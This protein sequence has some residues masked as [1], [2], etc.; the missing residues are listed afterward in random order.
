MRAAQDDAVRDLA[1]AAGVLVEWENY[2]GKR[3]EVAVDA[4][5]AVLTALGHPCGTDGDIAESR[6]RLAP[7]PGLD[8]LPPLITATEG[9][10][11]RLS[12]GAG[13]P[14][15]A[16]L[17]SETG[18]ERDLRLHP[19]RNGVEL[20]AISE[21]GYHRLLIG[22]RAL[23]L[24]VAPKHAPLPN[25][26]AAD[27]DDD[28]GVRPWGIA[29]QAYGLRRPG[30]GGIGDMECVALLAES[31]AR[32][33][34][35]MLA[36]SPLH[37]LFSAE[38]HRYGPYSPSSRL[39]LNPLYATPE[40]VLGQS[41]VARAAR[42][43]GVSAALARLEGLK[44]LDWAAAAEAK[45]AL[46]RALFGQFFSGA[47]IAQGLRADFAS[48]QAEGGQLLADHATFEALQHERV[49]HDPQSGDWRSW[50]A[51]LQDPRGPVVA[52]F[53]ETHRRE[54]LFHA[55]LQW[56]A[57]RSQAE[58]QARARRAGMRI[59]LIADLAVGMDA[60]GSHAWSRPQDI[61]R[62]LCV[63]APPDL[64]N[65]RGQQWGIT[66]FA[67]AALR[68]Q[69]FAPFLATLRAALRNA[70]GL[71]IDHAMGLQ[72]LWLVPEGASPADGAYV[73]YPL[74]DM[75]RLLALEA[76]RHRAVVIGE[77]LGTVP[78]GFRPALDEHGIHG[79][80]VLW[81]ERGDDG[82]TPPDRW[83]RAAASM[84]STHDLPTAAGW[85]SGADIALRASH[86]LLADQ[87]RAD[88]EA[89]R[90]RDKAA[91]WNAIV[92]D[93]AGEG[94]PPE[95][96]GAFV[97]AALAFVAGSACRLCLLPLEDLLGETDQ[98]NLPGTIDEH[99]NWRW[100]QSAPSAALL[101]SDAVAARLARVAARRGTAAGE[102]P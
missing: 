92:A 93:G 95:D 80:R 91:L 10:P 41:R 28:A 77:D 30:D 97:D 79:M 57:D 75:L 46:L 83:D 81:F 71:R 3:R 56:I 63:G 33:G 18:G 11:T 12:T 15:T 17:L 85:W 6:H 86:G 66:S 90:A 94:A 62:G 26:L 47:D 22:S 69:G 88:L 9:T 34:A 37:A 60:A 61:L 65:R 32:H 87:K 96:T 64:F 29:A 27:A 25:E 48:F 100:R 74:T 21:P 58:A 50:P 53:A 78:E 7:A 14:R 38:P 49:R 2:E 16:L 40:M 42:D 31:V 23:V 59:G 98:P 102:A 36:L 99:P 82:F 5:R 89:E 73:A 76:H 8:G 20:P 84:T 45:L 35:D 72:R 67:P 54:V 13:G 68:H 101:A 55:F 51:D 52:A 39:F 4:L 1:R 44:L 19:Y 43:A 24:A 70:G